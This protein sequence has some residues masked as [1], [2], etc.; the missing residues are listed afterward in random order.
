MVLPLGRP[1]HPQREQARTGHGLLILAG[2]R[3][4]VDHAALAG[5]AGEYLVEPVACR[6]LT[7]GVPQIRRWAAAGSVYGPWNR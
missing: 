3:L 2:E 4:P 5:F 6:R 1:G 7:L